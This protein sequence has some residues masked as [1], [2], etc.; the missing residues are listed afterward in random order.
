MKTLM[1]NRKC[2][3]LI[4]K[5]SMSTAP[6]IAAISMP[7]Y[8]KEESIAI[9]AFDDASTL[10][11]WDINTSNLV[12]CPNSLAYLASCSPLAYGKEMPFILNTSATCHISPEA[13][14]FKYL[15]SIPCHPV[16]GLSG[17]VVYTLGMGDKKLH[18]AGGHTLKLT[19][20]LYIPASNVRLISIIA[21]NRSGAYTTHFNLDTCWVTNKSN[22]TLVWGSISL[23]K[24]LYVLSTKEPLIQHQKHAVPSTVLYTRVPDIET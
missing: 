15:K 6:D 2:Y 9:V 23:P 7:T 1:I 18:I 24:C 4:T 12:E 13:S 8:D 17:L 11:N 16:K 10:V 19:N 21:L 22:M 14:D 5:A 20:T 3:M